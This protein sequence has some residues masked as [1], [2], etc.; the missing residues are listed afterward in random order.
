MSK[1]IKQLY[2]GYQDIWHCKNKSGSVKK[3]QEIIKSHLLNLKCN[4][5]QDEIGN[6]FVG[7]FTK[8]RPCLVAHMDSVHYKKPYKVKLVGYKLSAKNGIGADDKAGIVAGLE[9]LKSMNDINVLFTVD[10]EIGCI[11]AEAIEEEKLANVQYFIELDRQG[12]KEIINDMIYGYTASLEFCNTIQPIMKKYKYKFG[13]GSFTDVQV[14]GE[15]AEKS[16]INISCGYYNPHSNSEFQLLDELIESI[17][18]TK[19]ILGT[20]KKEFVYNVS[21]YNS[22]NFNSRYDSNYNDIMLD[23]IDVCNDI[24]SLIDLANEYFGE[25]TEDNLFVTNLLTKVYELGCVNGAELEENLYHN[26]T[27]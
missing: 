16:A 27:N 13:N 3:M 17:K 21:R 14:L 5:E 12:H 1:K 15:K 11:G 23:C 22:N 10:E 20:I 9:V 19:E 7:D 8:D 25:D 2:Y 18:L 6:I 26:S 24:P 4:F